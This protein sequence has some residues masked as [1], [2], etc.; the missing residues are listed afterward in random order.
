[1]QPITLQVKDLLLPFPGPTPAV[2]AGN[3]GCAR[4]TP[5]SSVFASYDHSTGTCAKDCIQAAEVKKATLN[6]IVLFIKKSFNERFLV[7]F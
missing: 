7:Y 1:M 6:I 2:I 3:V 5:G 4:T